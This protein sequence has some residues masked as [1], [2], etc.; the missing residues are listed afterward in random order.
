MTEWA[1]VNVRGPGGAGKS[2]LV[3][4]LL[5]RR[6]PIEPLALRPGSRQYQGVQAG[7]IRAVGDYRPACGGAEGMKQAEI[8]RLVRKYARE[9][10]VL[11]EGLLISSVVSRW[12]RL[13]VELGNVT[14]AFLCPPVEICVERT[15]A[16]N[17]ARQKP[18]SLQMDRVE[19]NIRQKWRVQPKHFDEFKAVGARCVWLPWEEDPLPALEALFTR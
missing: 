11:F 10:H 1:V 16:R 9:G 6:G 19:R 7:D 15:L 17:A 8:E 4:R 5:E 14:F 13:A 2:T 18:R 3:R 12:R